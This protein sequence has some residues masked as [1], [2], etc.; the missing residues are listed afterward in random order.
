MVSAVFNI[1]AVLLDAP[2]SPVIWGTV[3]GW[4]I[5]VWAATAVLAGIAVHTVSLI[6]HQARTLTSIENST[7]PFVEGFRQLS[8]PLEAYGRKSAP[9]D[10]PAGRIYH[11]GAGEIARLLMGSAEVNEGFMERLQDAQA[12]SPSQLE[13]ARV[14]MRHVLRSEIFPPLQG[15]IGR[16]AL[17]AQGSPWIGLVGSFIGVVGALHGAEMRRPEMTFLGLSPDLAW[18][19]MPGMVG[20][21][22]A[23]GS[24]VAHN[25]LVRRSVALADRLKDFAELFLAGCSTHYV[26][27]KQADRG[28]SPAAP[29]TPAAP[30]PDPVPAPIA[31]VPRSDEKRS[32]P[33][34]PTAA[35][36]P[37]PLESPPAIAEPLPAETVPTLTLETLAGF[38]AP[39]AGS[40][41]TPVVQ[42]YEFPPPAAMTK[43]PPKADPEPAPRPIDTRP[44]GAESRLS[45]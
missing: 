29:A 4:S 23:G 36:P 12:L 31:V 2:V 9:Q 43:P 26:D 24:L 44:L 41:K 25:A 16:L 21:L 11:A 14:A 6:R 42:I 17:I 40:T 8:E 20:L 1:P 38:S 30:A 10:E 5:G 33:P 15:K 37:S 39:S 32:A 22:V 19:L 28:F 27:H 3:T 45:P 7:G 13:P 18:S 35:L 34:P